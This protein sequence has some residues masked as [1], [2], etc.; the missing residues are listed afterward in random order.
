MNGFEPGAIG[1]T[2]GGNVICSAAVS[3][4]IDILNDPHLQSNVN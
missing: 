3:A 4:T 1:G 2:Y